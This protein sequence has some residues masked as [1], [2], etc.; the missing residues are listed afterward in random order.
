VRASNDH[1]DLL[2]V[3]AV[4]SLMHDFWIAGGQPGIAYAVVA[5]GELVHTAGIGVRRLGGP[6]PDADTVFRIASMTKSFT[7]SAVLMLRDEGL[8]R[9][10]DEVAEYVPEVAALKPPT[11]DA[12][13]IT[14]RS[15]LTM[16]AGLP[17]DDPW[18]DRRQDLPDEEF[19]KLLTGG[20]SFTWTPGT[21]Y[22]YSNLGYALLGR[23]ITAAAGRP[24]SE[25]VTERL[26]A[27][28]GMGSTVFTADAVPADRLAQGYRRE[29]P[30][31]HGR[32]A[33]LEVPF[34]RYGAFA[35]MGG[36]FSSVRDLAR[37]V[38]GFSSAYPPRDAEPAGEHPLR[39]SSRREMQQPHI[40]LPATITWSS[41]AA[42]PAV[43]S[44]GYGFGLLVE[45]DPQFGALV[46]HSGGYPGFGSHMRW[47]P[48]SGLGV[49]VL[50]NSTYAAAG[51]IGS[52]ILDVLLAGRPGGRGPGAS[53]APASGSMVAATAAARADVDRLITDWD[54]AL[55][56]R[57]F[58]D[59]VD[60]DEPLSRRRT[61]IER[62]ITEYGPLIPDPDEPVASNSPAHCVWWLSGAG[63]RVRVEIRLTP[64]SP[65]LV[66]T[67]TVAGVPH[68]SP[69]VRA[70]AQAVAEWLGHDDPGQLDGLSLAARA[71]VAELTRQLRAGGVWAGRCTVSGVLS[72]DG[73][74]DV[75]FRLAGE[76]MPL[77]LQLIVDP[78]SG[79]IGT[80][81][82]SPLSPVNPA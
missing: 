25:L 6:A 73:I 65:P 2:D 48:A 24:Y 54:D 22:E 36:L 81:T 13:P 20:L 8:L 58:A 69:R 63:G 19:A 77:Q 18:G 41:V 5:D 71:D 66:Q 56:A 17:T 55:A 52:R 30:L 45:D 80:L 64:Q 78:A 29:E 15:L 23:V 42:P 67:L 53:P 1:R 70:A 61:A 16:T 79:G 74:R 21:A 39:R 50:G 32:R 37:W 7:A 10:D 40:G 12:A 44:T 57:L 31:G 3:S 60:A 28:L 76:R 43:R 34:A 35:S 11:D 59:N 68:P 27:P 62:L 75:T 46:S 51:R 33:W 9:L 82:L 4:E 47:H 38:G 14:V 72:G 49:I 26:L